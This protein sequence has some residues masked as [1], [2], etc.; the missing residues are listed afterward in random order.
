MDLKFSYGNGHISFPHSNELGR[1]SGI[2]ALTLS[3]YLTLISE[4]DSV[5]SVEFQGQGL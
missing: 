3:M 4:T 1:P 5:Y 2:K